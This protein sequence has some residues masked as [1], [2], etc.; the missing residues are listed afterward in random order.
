VLEQGVDVVY[1]WVNGSDPLLR[2]ELEA[3]LAEE[4]AGQPQQGP[5]PHQG[6]QGQQ[7]GQHTEQ[8]RHVL[9][10]QTG[11]SRSPGLAGAK[12]AG[13]SSGS[14]ALVGA[15]AS[16]AG[17]FD[18]GRDELRFSLR[19]LQQHLPWFRRLWIVT[20]GQVGTWRRRRVLV[21]KQCSTQLLSSVL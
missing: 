13:K 12:P 15:Q 16:N 19:S 14:S 3:A 9:R 4:A 2:A 20:N 17:R 1:L 7:Q 21:G 10:A 6:Q 8:Q 11:V 5:L 18:S